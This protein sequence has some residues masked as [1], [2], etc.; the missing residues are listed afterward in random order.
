VP[1][2]V[3][4]FGLAAIALTVAAAE[5][6]GAVAV[7]LGR[8]IYPQDLSAPAAA[9]EPRNDLPPDAQQRAREERLRALVWSAVFE[10]YTRQRQIETTEAE[11]GSH[12]RHHLALR[13]QDK[14][15]RERER[16]RLTEELKS[17]GPADARRRQA[18]Q[19]LDT[20]TQIEEHEARLTQERQD[21][22]RAKMWQDAERRV[23]QLWVKRWKVNQALHRE[24]GG[25]VIFQQAGWEPIDAYRRL[26]EQYQARKAFVVH[27]PQLW[28]AVY[29]YFKYSF[30]YADEAKARFYFEKPWWERTPE[31]MSA[32][33]F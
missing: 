12:I 23:A 14:L 25:R 28:D 4:G 2:W 1:R 33:G 29:G 32:A 21:P 22:A 24:F 11:V 15:R 3:T 9:G 30:V 5:P 13:E 31:E 8:A 10:D 6:L 20:L 19:Y 26:L 7:V 17:P 16:E 18:Q 27:D